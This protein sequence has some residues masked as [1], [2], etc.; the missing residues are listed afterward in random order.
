MGGLLQG[1]G[2]ALTG[3]C[4]STVFVQMSAGIRTGWIVAAGGILGGILYSGYSRS[5]R[6]GNPTA[7]QSPQLLTVHGRYSMKESHA[8]LGLE[9]V[10][11][12]VVGL[13]IL[14]E[15]QR[16]D[17][18]LHPIVGGLLMG[19][20]Q[21]SSLLFTGNTLGVSSAYEQC[22]QI[23]WWLLSPFTKGETNHQKKPAMGALPFAAGVMAG[24]WALMHTIFLPV[25]QE[26]GQISAIRA[27]LG[28]TMLAFGARLAGGCTSG[29]GIS[30][31]STLSISSFVTVAS[32]FA[33]G[34]GLAAV[35]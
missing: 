15:P 23:F 12:L 22:G 9:M 16:S 17:L 19:G 35:L 5:L 7:N 31:M 26:A 11:A 25:P 10:F 14:I 2:M 21:A 20:S 13:A 18:L 8:I 6:S 30:G 28:G 34:I 1:F 4:A 27:L 29:H 3:A 32:M 24:A 33:G